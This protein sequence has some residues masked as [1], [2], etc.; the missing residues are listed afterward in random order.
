MKGKVVRV[1]SVVG[2]VHKL[3]FG[4]LFSA[5]AT[6]AGASSSLDD[7][8]GYLQIDGSVA[9][10]AAG[11]GDAL[12]VTA[13]DYT[14]F[15]SDRVVTRHGAAVLKID[16]GGALGVAPDSKV[17][18]Q[19]GRDAPQL[20]ADL[21]R[22]TLLFNLPGGTA[23]VRIDSG[24]FSVRSQPIDARILR[25]R[26]RDADD[27]IGWVERHD[28]GHLRAAVSSGELQIVDGRGTV[29]RVLAGSEI[30]LLAIAGQENRVDAQVPSDRLVRIEAPEQVATG[31]SFRIRWE[32]TVDPATGQGE[33]FITIAPAGA[34]PEEFERV[35]STGE[36]SVLAFDAPDAAG[37]Y[38][39]RFV[40]GN[41]GEVS[42][43]VYLNVVGDEAAAPWISSNPALAAGLTLAAAGGG[44]IVLIGDDDDDGPTS[45]SP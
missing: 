44:A 43:F 31:E 9:V 7:P 15:P 38:E 40:D 16:G 26:M 21:E 37:D 3:L 35:M 34:A 14:I 22:G 10:Q 39:I 6:L 32:G 2:Q 41:T 18:F 13:D 1:A 17:A 42:S 29:H 19:A 27:L 12:P 25:V 45:V 20:V 5:S 23:P 36:G 24:N 11:A 28:D 8:I 4:G 33:S 30:G